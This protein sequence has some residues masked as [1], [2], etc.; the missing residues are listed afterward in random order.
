[1]DAALAR[2]YSTVFSP[3]YVLLACTLALVAVE[4]RRGH[5]DGRLVARLGVVAAAW[6]LAFAVYRSAP[7]VFDPVPVWAGDLLGG[8]GLAAAFVLIGAAWRRFAWGP[9]VPEFAAVVVVV[10]VVHSLVTPFWDVSSHVLYTAVPAGYLALVDRRTLPVVVV[11]LGMTA[12]R[13]LAGAHTW[14]QS[15]AGLVAAGLLVGLVA[16]YRNGRGR[17]AEPPATTDEP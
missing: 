15:V 5:R 13:P 14:T 16:T 11:P 8:V 7:L 6:L 3:E 4:R 9:V 2:L 1:M 10:S 12:S 17:T